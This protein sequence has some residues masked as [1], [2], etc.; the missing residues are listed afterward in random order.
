MNIEGKQRKGSVAGMKY[1]MREGKSC[2][3][4]SFNLNFETPEEIHNE[5][6]LISSMNRN[7][8]DKNK[9]LGG[10]ISFDTL[11]IP[12]KKGQ[13]PTEETIQLLENIV[14]DYAKEMN[15]FNNQWRF[16][17]HTDSD[18]L[19]LHFIANRTDLNGK[20]SVDVNW[21]GL[22]AKKLATKLSKKYG[23]KTMKELTDMKVAKINKAL[24]ISLVSATSFDE[25]NKLM[26]KIVL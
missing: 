20:T 10:F 5:M 16:D 18:N 3:G 4:K 1:Q 14:T 8:K 22:K 7:L 24:D 19:H 11:Q 23:M 15:F 6:V 2:Y 21:S 26:N 13:K 12:H 17:I 9:F 25:L